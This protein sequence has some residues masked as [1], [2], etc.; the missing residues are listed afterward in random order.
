MVVCAQT[1]T[2]REATLTTTSN[3]DANCSDS[4]T[5]SL[6]TTA[7]PTPESQDKIRPSHSKAVT[8][9][10][11][12]YPAGETCDER[13][14]ATPKT[15]PSAYTTLHKIEMNTRMNT[16]VETL[17]SIDP[18]VHLSSIATTD[19]SPTQKS[20]NAIENTNTTITRPMCLRT[21]T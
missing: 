5:T 10:V 17:I 1:S 2:T 6:D 16:G 20:V 11:L 15:M 13:P 14:A 21:T 4:V 12:R 19:S 3:T 7:R 9:W 18:S 8:W